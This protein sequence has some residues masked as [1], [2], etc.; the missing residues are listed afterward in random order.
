MFSYNLPKQKIL[1]LLTVSLAFLLRAQ[2]PTFGSPSLFYSNDEAIAHI[3]ALNMISTRSLVSIANYTPLAAYMQLP[4]VGITFLI[5]LAGSYIDSIEEFR[6]L[7]LTHEGY[8]LFIPRLISICFGT[9]SV[10]AM[11]KFSELLF[12]DRRVS[13]I[14]AFLMATS[15][16]FVHISTTGRP[17]SVAVFFILAFLVYAVKENLTKALLT[18][19]LAYASHQIA[20]FLIPIWFLLNNLKQKKKLLS[21]IF[22]IVTFALLNSLTPSVNLKDSISSGASFLRSDGVVASLISGDFAFSS[23]NETISGNLVPNF[24]SVLILSDFAIFVGGLAGIYINRKKLFAQR[25]FLFVV[26]YFLFASL[27]FHLV[28]RYLIPVLILLIPFSASFISNLRPKTL[29]IAILFA[30]SVNSVYWNTL[31]I[32]NSTT[33]NAMQW[34]NENISGDAVLF[35]TGGRYQAFVPSYEMINVIRKVDESSYKRL[36]ALKL[37][38]NSDNVKNILY[39][40]QLPGPNKFTKLENSLLLIKPDYI[41]DY[42]YTP[43]DSLL[44]NYSDR[45]SLIKS[46]W[47][48]NKLD[49]LIPEFYFEAGYNFDPYSPF[50]RTSMYSISTP[51]PYVD[52]LV[53][54]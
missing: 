26:G 5:G 4:L 54:K 11:Y 39:T 13:A 45:F 9:L 33:Q 27:F 8:L 6:K 53:L 47:P 48:T 36:E 46:F 7:I 28:T 16:T 50:P 32:K 21:I 49:Q 34:I 51:G 20:I 14:S 38:S 23:L 40:G 41:V 43:N 17:W 44:K 1:L 30:A 37:S 31:F 22:L 12:S 29:L 2:N 35:Y 25:V 24:L 42:Y 18:A 15:F 10:I 52:I 19:V 3:T